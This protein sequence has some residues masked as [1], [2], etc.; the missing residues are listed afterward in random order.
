MYLYYTGCWKNPTCRGTARGI[1]I[2]DEDG[3]K[4]LSIIHLLILNLM[5]QTTSQA[6]FN[7][8]RTS[9]KHIHPKTPPN[10]RPRKTRGHTQLSSPQPSPGTHLSLSSLPPQIPRTVTIQPSSHQ[11]HAA[12]PIPSSTGPGRQNTTDSHHATPRRQGLGANKA[13]STVPR[14]TSRRGY[15]PRYLPTYLTDGRTGGLP[16]DGRG[17]MFKPRSHGVTHLPGSIRSSKYLGR[18]QTWWM[19]PSM[20]GFHHHHPLSQYYQ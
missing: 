10:I 2:E 18:R 1:R 15:L 5:C 17:S 20:E 19:P 16:T 6:Q 8:Q 11:A 4:T 14:A 3:G 12:V 7:P 13:P 9:N